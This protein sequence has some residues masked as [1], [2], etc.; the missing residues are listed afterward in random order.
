MINL[1]PA[2]DLYEGQ[3]VR[4]QK[5]DFEKKTVYSDNPGA[6]AQQFENQGAQWL[7]LVDLE[8]AKTGQIK[9]WASLKQI[10]KTVRA[11]LEF[12]GGIRTLE[13]LRQ[14]SDLGI[15]RMILG[16][17]AL[18][19]NFLEMAVIKFGS[20][21]AVGLDIRNGL[22]QTQ[23]W[24]EA[25]ALTLEAAIEF[26]NKLP[27]ETLI[28][29]DIQKDGMLEGPNFAKLEEVMKLAKA[30]IILSGGVAR[31]EDIHQCVKIQNK[32]FDGV[33]IGKAL[34]EKRFTLTEAVKAV[35][36]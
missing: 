28:Y 10:R 1:Y 34:Y 19:K 31:I 11:K 13:D 17:K 7:H 36:K 9:N 23:G 24:L 4:L 3:V 20:K 5:G 21:I 2:I 32:N 18:E 8:G 26:L 29:T 15:D 35:A 27:V 16:T 22:V 12:G 14:L 33:I 25:E 6:M 30:N